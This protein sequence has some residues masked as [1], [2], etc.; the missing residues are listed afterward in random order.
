MRDSQYEHLP[1]PGVGVTHRY[2]PQVHILSQPW[3]MSL[4]AELCRPET[5][6]PRFNQLLTLLFD[7][8]LPEI[9]GRELA[10]SDCERTTR[11]PDAAYRGQIVDPDQAAVV[12]AV[13]RGG[14]PPAQRFYDHLNQLL[15]P[16][17]VR[18]DHLFM[19]RKTD[20]DG[21]VVG[22]DVSGS[23]LGGGVQ[24][25]TLLIPDP[26][27]ATGGSI[28]QT[29]EIYRDQVPGTPRRVVC[30]HLIITPEYIRR[31]LSAFPEAHIYT[32]RLDRGLSTPQALAQAP[33]TLWDQEKGLN[34]HDYIVPGAGGLG[35]LMNNAWV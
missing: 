30:A 31:V 25:A 6:Q 18:Q 11:M 27:G 26:M 12:A 21:H 32:I 20:A 16:S 29:L 35:E 13:A 9:V 33:G 14:I 2:G 17:K 24:D 5:T 15:D 1:G 4:L 10:L 19:A 3:P 34:D 8:M 28:V 23:K 7:W 22:V